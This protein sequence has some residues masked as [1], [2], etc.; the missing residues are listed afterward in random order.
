M[1]AS[2]GKEG[3]SPRCRGRCGEKVWALFPWVGVIA[4][5]VCRHPGG[6]SPFDL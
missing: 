3:G 6:Q 5:G 4:S 1:R 2:R